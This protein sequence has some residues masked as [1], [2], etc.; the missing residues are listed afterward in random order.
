MRYLLLVC[1]EE[2]VTL[3]P[4]ERAAIPAATQDWVD[5]TTGRGAGDA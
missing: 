2:D 5:E 4:E 1:A 3:S